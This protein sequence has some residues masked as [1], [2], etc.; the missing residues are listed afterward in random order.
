M[1]L[2]L[3]LLGALLLVLV[4]Y[5]RRRRQPSGSSRSPFVQQRQT[6][7]GAA[8]LRFDPEQ[9]RAGDGPD[10]PSEDDIPTPQEMKAVA[11]LRERVQGI[12]DSIVGGE[13]WYEDCELLRYVRA[14]PSLGESEQ[15]FREAM[16]L[17]CK[18]ARDWGAITVAG[19][20]GEDFA[21][22]REI[23]NGTVRAANGA[24]SPPDWWTFL[25]EHLPSDIYGSDRNGLP[26]AYNC[27]GKADMQG[28]VREVGLEVLQRYGTMNND[29][30]LD[31]A[32]A[33]TQR[34]RCGRGTQG[35]PV[36]H[37]GIVILDMEGLSFRHMGEVKVF[38][39][40]SAAAKVLHPE[41]QR[42]MFLVRCPKIFGTVWGLVKGIIDPRTAE[43]IIIIS[44]GESM[45]P[46][47]SELGQENVPECLGGKAVLRWPLPETLVPRGAFQQHRATRGAAT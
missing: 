39:L 26:I 46:L 38:K 20:F 44:A 4:A 18:Q 16:S 8:T 25:D 5:R 2:A 47:V 32:R 31:C 34:R 12:A 17:R 1:L 11:Q 33:A 10:G 24:T 21:R 7:G 40:I 37:G 27:I 28:L 41:R 36:V 42:K 13:R 19:S 9:G 3:G 45:A 30:F 43:R 29:Y 22:Y 23:R 14:R 15:L 35:G 6:S